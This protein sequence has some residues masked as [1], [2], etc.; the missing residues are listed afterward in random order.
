MKLEIAKIVDQLYIL[1]YMK[2]TYSKELNGN[3]EFILGWL[4]YQISFLM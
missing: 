4:N 3:Y 1:P 2:I